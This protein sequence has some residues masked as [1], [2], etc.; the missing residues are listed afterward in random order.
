MKGTLHRVPFTF[1]LFF[2]YYKDNKGFYMNGD[3]KQVIVM[4]KDLNMRKGKIAAQA[5]HASLKVF[6]DMMVKDRNVDHHQ[7]RLTLP[8]NDIGDAMN[9][10]IEGLFTKIC[11]SVNS[12]DELMVIY[13]MACDANLPCSLI[14]DAGLTEFAGVPTK[15]CLAIGPARSYL[16]DQ[17]TGKLPL[18]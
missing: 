3:V 18:L 7:Y 1:C 10:W 11:V 8:D 4:R 16:I 2:L 6:F 13:K 14:V 5:S 15:T 9:D 12:E 17:I